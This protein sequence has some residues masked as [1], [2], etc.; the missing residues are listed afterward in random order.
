MRS[1]TQS[2]GCRKSPPAWHDEFM[3]M[4]PAITRHARIAFRYLDPEA[5]QGAVQEVVCN[6]CQAYARLVELGKAAV[7]YPTVLASYAVAQTK[8]G[9][10]VGGRLN[11]GDV[12]SPYA[13]RRKCFVVERL[14]RYDDDEGSWREILVEDK[15]ATA[16]DVACVRLDFEAWLGTLSRRYRRIAETLATGE[17]TTRA[18]RKFRLTTGRI[19]QIRTL[20]MSSG[21]QFQGELPSRICPAAA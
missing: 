18:A 17:T 1:S 14:D 4:M 3:A 13:Q 2:V 8:D 15:R 11:V 21:E 10:K 12:L 5:R 9:R 19:S 16:A 20:L 6:A 7:A